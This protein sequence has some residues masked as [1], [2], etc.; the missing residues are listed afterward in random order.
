MS[1]ASVPS[2]TPR[3]VQELIDEIG[4]GRFQRRLLLVCGVTWA[5]DAAELLA[6]GFALPGIRE[7]F[8]LSASQAGLV[9][10]STFVGMLLGAA[11][12][13]TVSDRIGRRTGFQATVL[14]FAVFGLASAFA[15]SVEALIVL[16]ILT[17]FGLGGALPLDFS[18][19]AEYL[20]RRNRGRYLVLLESFWAVGTVAIALLA[21]AVV[22]NWG[23]RPLLALSGL[24]ALLVFWIRRRVPES[25]RYLVTVG[26][27]EQAR[28]VLTVVAEVNGRPSPLPPVAAVDAPRGGFA[29][30]WR[31]PVRSTTVMLWLAWFG[32]GL[33]YYGLFV[34]LPTIFVARGFSFLQT[35]GYALVL[36]AAQIPGY[37]SAAWLVEAWGRRGTLILYLCASGLFTLLFGVADSTGLIVAAASLMS[38]FSLGAWAALYAY[39]PES[40]PTPIRATGMGWAS[41]TTRVAAALVTFFGATLIAG[42]LGLALALFAAAFVVA[43]SGVAILG[44]ETRGSALADTAVGVDSRPRR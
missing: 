11:F 36:A 44:R 28:D 16:R 43:A 29:D 37:L 27:A 24:A 18:L 21:F 13:G 30:L 7:E 3:P 42:S 35:Y 32:I 20:P 34:Y 40:Y 19:M 38:F 9:A 33:A 31:S 10:S 41:A 23:W 4:F 14:I 25:P 26:R 12:W 17:G 5:A 2:S 15:P 1:G 39:T 8:G 22:P 6:I